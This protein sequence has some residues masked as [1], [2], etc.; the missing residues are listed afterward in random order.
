LVKFL[1][2]LVF[3]ACFLI[4]VLTISILPQDSEGAL[5]TSLWTGNG[6]GISWSDPKNWD[7]FQ[8]DGSNLNNIISIDSEVQLDIDLTLQNS[9]TVY[10]DGMLIIEEGITLKIE[11]GDLTITNGGIL[12]NYGTIIVDGGLQYPNMEYDEP[13]PGPIYNPDKSKGKMLFLGKMDVDIFGLNI[14]HGKIFCTKNSVVNIEC[15]SSSTAQIP[16]WVKFNAK[17]WNEGK[18]D[19]NTFINAMEYLI[20][21]NIVVLNEMPQEIKSTT[22]GIPQWVKTGAGL[23]NDEKIPDKTFLDS[24]TYLVKEG[25]IAKNTNSPINTPVKPTAGVDEVMITLHR[26]MCFGT[27]PVYDLKIL[28]S[29]S[30]IFYGKN[31]VETEGMV[32]YQIE[33]SDVQTLIDL[34]YEKDFFSLYDRYEDRVTDQPSTTT[35]FTVGNFTKSVYNYGYRVAPDTLIEI[36]HKIDQIANSEKYIGEPNFQF[37]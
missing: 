28:G 11:G 26:G 22:Q 37:P 32:K 17:L 8:P 35:S 29:G 7:R 19:D 16:S 5:P 23:W 33:T 14:N 21:Q 31:F 13:M 34:F 24:M 1:D 18:I 9:L 25:I 12:E 4:L 27:C 36:E 20:E 2:K 6:D 10:K 30:V 3:V 15:V